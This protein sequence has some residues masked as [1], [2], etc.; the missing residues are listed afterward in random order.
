MSYYNYK[1]DDEHVNKNNY[2]FKSYTKAEKNNDSMMSGDIEPPDVNIAPQVFQ[3]NQIGIGFGVKG[4][5]GIK[6]IFGES[7]DKGDRG[8]N[9]SI[10]VKGK[11]GSAGIIGIKGEPGDITNFEIGVKFNIDTSTLRDSDIFIYKQ[12]D[13]IEESYWTNELLD[14]ADIN[15]FKEISNHTD[16]NK[17]YEILLDT[18]NNWKLKEIIIDVDFPDIWNELTINNENT[19]ISNRKTIIYN[20]LDVDN[21]LN[22][23]NG[24]ETRGNI[25]FNALNI[26]EKSLL[27]NLNSSQFIESRLFQ[28]KIANDIYVKDILPTYPFDDT[29]LIDTNKPNSFFSNIGSEN[30][31]FHTI[32]AHD[33]AIDANSIVVGGGAATYTFDTEQGGLTSSVKKNDGSESIIKTVTTDP[34]DPNTIDP[35][36]LRISGLS[37]LDTFD[38]ALI[39]P[40]DYNRE[41]N[42]NISNAGNYL[43]CSEDG[44]LGLRLNDTENEKKYINRVLGY[45]KKGDIILWSGTSWVKIPFSIP[46]AYIQAVMLDK[47]SVTTE[48]IR[49]DSVT[50]DKLDKSTIALPIIENEKF[51]SFND[52]VFSKGIE[53]FND[54]SGSSNLLLDGDIIT[55]G[56]IIINN[57]HNS[58]NQIVGPSQIDNRLDINGETFVNNILNVIG[59]CQLNNDLIVNGNSTLKGNLIL[60]GDITLSKDVNIG[61]KLFV[62][63]DL[64]AYEN[65]IVHS[66]LETLG[67]VNIA[68]ILISNSIRSNGDVDVT[69]DINVN[70]NMTVGKNVNIGK[71]TLISGTLIT[72]ENATFNKDIAVGDMIECSKINVRDQLILSGKFIFNNDFE[73]SKDVY[74]RRDLYVGYDLTTKEIIPNAGTINI[75][76]NLNTLGINTF[77]GNTFCMSN[78]TIHGDVGSND[79]YIDNDLLVNNNIKV[80]NRLDSIGFTTITDLSVNT[81]N[82]Y[83][84]AFFKGG[85]NIV[86]DS[87]IN[88]NLTGNINFNNTG[89]ISNIGNILNQ[90]D[91]TTDRLFANNINS[92]LIES[93]NF[94]GGDINVNNG[95]INGDFVINGKLDISG[96]TIIT[97][98]LI[99]RGQLISDSVG[100][101]GRVQFNSILQTK[102]I[103]SDGIITA[104]G[105]L[106]NGFLTVTGLSNLNKLSVGNNIDPGNDDLYVEGSSLFKGN[107]SING[108]L[109]INGSY[110][111]I[112]TDI[113]TTEQLEV[114]NDGTGPAVI[115]RQNNQ[116]GTSQPI[117]KF[118]DGNYNTLFAGQDK[119]FSTT[120]GEVNTLFLVSNNVNNQLS[121]INLLKIG[122]KIT[123][124]INQNEQLESIVKTINKDNGSIVLQ[125]FLTFS[126]PAGTEYTFRFIN[127]F[128]T[129]YVGDNS[130]IGIGTENP[131]VTLYIN[132]TDAI[133]IPSGTTAHRSDIENLENGL[134]RYNTELR[135]YEGYSNESWQ[136][137]G[138]LIDID[139]DTFISSMDSDQ[140]DTDQLVFFTAG[141]QR[142]VIDSSY[143]NGFIGINT[144]NPQ[145]NLDVS[146]V[147]NG[148]IG[149]YTL[150]TSDNYQDI[151]DNKTKYPD[152]FD[153]I[154]VN[155]VVPYE[156]KYSKD[157]SDI[158]LN[159]DKESS[160]SESIANFDN[161]I[162]RNMFMQPP[163]FTD[164]SFNQFGTNIEIKWTLPKRYKMAYDDKLLP[165]I[166]GI[167]VE[168]RGGD[169]ANLINDWVSIINTLEEPPG[170]SIDR[171]SSVKIY[172][173]KA[174]PEPSTT[175]FY[176]AR[177]TER[178]GKELLVG[179]KYDFRIYGYN[180]STHVNNYNYFTDLFI[181]AMGKPTKVRDISHNLLKIVNYI[182]V[183]DGNI[184]SLDISNIDGDN[185]YISQNDVNVNFSFIRPIYS[186]DVNNEINQPPLSKF[187]INYKTNGVYNINNRQNSIVGTSSNNDFS[188]FGGE[189][190]NH[191]ELNTNDNMITP[192]QHS[193]ISN[194][195]Y[196]DERLTGLNPGHK[197]EISIQASNNSDSTIYGP[198]SN[199][200]IIY[201]SAPTT[202]NGKH[203]MLNNKSLKFNGL[204]PKKGR[205]LNGDPLENNH[206]IFNRSD[207][208]GKTSDKVSNIIINKYA[209][210]KNTN[211]S[212]I[213]L[214]FQKKNTDSGM[215]TDIVQTNYIDIDGFDGQNAQDNYNN[216]IGDDKF[217]SLNI[218]SHSDL[219]GD[220]IRDGFWKKINIQLEFLGNDYWRDNDSY[221]NH[222]FS[223]KIIHRLNTD[224]G[225]LSYTSNY[226]N[227]NQFYVEKIQDSIKPEIGKLW[228]END[229]PEIKYVSGIPTYDSGSIF[230][231]HIN[232]KY[233]AGYYLREDTKHSKVWLSPKDSNNV[234]LSEENEIKRNN[235][236]E[237]FNT[238]NTGYIISTNKHNTHGQNLEPM[239]NEYIQFNNQEIALDNIT[240]TYEDIRINAESY[241]L[242][243]NDSK[244]S[245][246]L[247]NGG[248]EKYIRCDKNSLNVIDGL[249]NWY[250]SSSDGPFTSVNGTYS[251]EISFVDKQYELHLYNGKICN[252]ANITFNGKNIIENASDYYFPNGTIKTPL[253]NINSV[254]TSTTTSGYK[255]AIFSFITTG[256]VD[257]LKF[258]INGSAGHSGVYDTTGTSYVDENVILYYKLS[259]GDYGGASPPATGWMSLNL[260]GN[261][262]PETF[263][264]SSDTRLDGRNLLFL[265]GSNSFIRYT[266]VP[267]G[268]SNLNGYVKIGIK[269]DNSLSFTNIS[270]TGETI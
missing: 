218:T 254:Y 114:V 239:Y 115:F 28:T 164:L 251:H 118:V 59:K 161:W 199:K 261:P 165:M 25:N 86:G 51:I 227:N 265:S 62:S 77:E 40:I 269:N 168:I 96:E 242:Y 133:R 249:H 43:V 41:Y 241:N 153:Y 53:V 258:T 182:A 90:N 4:E 154:N 97:N 151:K 226:I 39:S 189:K 64:V 252:L 143:N 148:K 123:I 129:L 262:N 194:D 20:D 87:V 74:I 250:F 185:V 195:I 60:N 99:L 107:V 47:N 192:K 170:G 5:P 108:D 210:D 8:F 37:F 266:Q 186:D 45:I 106:D 243:E 68:G 205:K 132:G 73:F 193:T 207:L 233:L 229:Q 267:Q 180:D 159:I 202:G 212:D 235:N 35:K 109:L 42:L 79:V 34:M 12:K 178:V 231:Y 18:S 29:N 166:N 105:I 31:K 131:G 160:I 116:V 190:T 260:P 78:L 23:N 204:V 216:A 198:D 71:N 95:N 200:I 119:C 66:N 127:E 211:L 27:I 184:F 82:S 58:L 145:C 50:F 144:N 147:I 46:I 104:K 245:Q 113:T 187:K 219:Y 246:S 70:R 36:F 15:E 158:G 203:D 259:N 150:D 230:K 11:K 163:R 134:I 162:L 10:G 83:N 9:G 135:Q 102:D 232:N 94:K 88:G 255:W 228:F 264:Q 268:S 214:T 1:K 141:E 89:N 149:E 112:D 172:N 19:I 209:C 65:L 126:E 6:G 17:H 157:I 101:S 57:I 244:N 237:Y 13:T 215:V 120:T 263:G 125:E 136:G 236:P 48:K 44:N 24:F 220:N 81:M 32:Y 156:H 183:N 111:Q 33:L 91:I 52:Y 152:D 63:N 270:V 67:N 197:Y 128:S 191:N 225:K 3:N 177:L 201:T 139:Q 80:V 38:P 7:G 54:I 93:D 176:G 171:L 175:N 167:N 138:G 122:S 253:A 140:N 117:A 55:N 75:A 49:N 26:N 173:S 155:N 257:R 130:K 14:L 121:D 61:S 196:N 84:K 92:K 124:I 16:F 248:N 22:V 217:I 146:G 179:K 85:V 142:M 76:K 223:Y 224:F 240:T 137:L 256:I 72:Q 234:V 100:A 247:R 110:R 213:S 2:G 222:Y 30:A 69:N 206:D 208:N 188:R 221:I 181:L 21:K 56:R 98:N 174:N 169:G 103:E 238:D